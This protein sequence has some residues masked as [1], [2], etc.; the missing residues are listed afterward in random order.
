MDQARL[1]R[2]FSACDVNESGRIEYEDFT[3]VCRELGV[4]ETHIKTLFDKFDANDDG[5]IDY[6]KF[7]SRFQE[8][9]E[10][11]D[12]ASFGTGWSHNR[13][14]SWDVMEGGRDAE[15]LVSER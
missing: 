15:A 12:L 4:P 2:L 6:S 9:S 11:V 7:S 13:G 8:V 5:Y 10:V 14:C 3:A 1:R